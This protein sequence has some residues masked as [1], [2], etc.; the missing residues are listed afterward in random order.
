MEYDNKMITVGLFLLIFMTCF[1]RTNSGKAL[2][3]QGEYTN[4]D[5]LNG[6]GKGLQSKEPHRS[7]K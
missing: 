2:P 3:S 7:N 1:Y 6:S 4:I 5:T